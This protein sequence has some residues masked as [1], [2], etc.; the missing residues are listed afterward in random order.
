MKLEKL[1]EK[2]EYTLLKGS[3]D[4]DIRDI[5]YDSRKVEDN[6]VFVSIV[7]SNV[8]GHNYIDNAIEL[9][10]SVIIVSKD[11]NVDSDVTVV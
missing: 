8:D 7:G 10:A 5:A 6:Y 11:V 4:V 2:I 9:G 3:L 1:L